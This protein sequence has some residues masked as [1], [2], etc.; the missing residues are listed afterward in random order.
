[1][2]LKFKYTPK[3]EIDLSQ[4]KK[5]LDST[6]L[7]LFITEYEN[8]SYSIILKDGF[9]EVNDGECVTATG[10]FQNAVILLEKVI[11]NNKK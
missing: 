2:N 7:G 3:S 11:L 4:L 9:F 10:D 5:E 8:N 6:T 1:M